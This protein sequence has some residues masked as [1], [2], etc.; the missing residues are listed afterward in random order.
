M[1]LK[2]FAIITGLSS[3]ASAASTLQFSATTGTTLGVLTNLQSSMSDATSAKIWGVLVDT[4]AA[5]DGFLT[6]GSYQLGASLAAST[7]TVLSSLS[8]VSND[9]LA[10]ASAGMLSSTNT[11]LDGG[12]VGSLARP[13]SITLAYTNGI[14][15]GQKFALIWFDTTIN[16]AGTVVASGAKYGLLTNAAFVL[17][18]DGT[19][20]FDFRPNFVGVDPVNTANLSVVPEPSAALLGV[21]GVFGLLRRRRN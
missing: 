7:Q 17:P 4:S 3:L 11:T 5:Q 2:V 21:I 20:A 14:A 9:V 15:V 8:G 18:A 13:G 19:A 10:I 12:T 16:T 1:K 6:S